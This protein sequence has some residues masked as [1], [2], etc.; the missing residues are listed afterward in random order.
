MCLRKG[1][2]F[3]YRHYR[4]LVR[5]AIALNHCTVYGQIQYTKRP[6]H[7]CLLNKL[8]Q[9][10]LVRP[11]FNVKLLHDWSNFDLPKLMP[12]EYIFLMPSSCLSLTLIHTR[13]GYTPI[14]Y[15]LRLSKSGICGRQRPQKW[16]KGGSHSRRPF[17]SLPYPPPFFPLLLSP[18]PFDACYA[19]YR[20]AAFKIRLFLTYR[21]WYA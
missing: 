6:E 2:S 20:K 13:I 15:S 8:L 18:T 12:V 16:I 5:V 3:E 11:G 4:C 17:P 19:G 21:L 7:L 1:R 14:S 9:L 10:V